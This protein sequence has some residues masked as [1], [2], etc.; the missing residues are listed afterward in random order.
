MGTWKT[1]K[2]RSHVNEIQ[3]E[4]LF[5]EMSRALDSINE[6]MEFC[7]YHYKEIESLIANHMARNAD[8]NY[9]QLRFTEDES[10][11]NNEY[12]FTVACKAHIIALIRTLHSLPDLIA[13]VIYIS[14]GLNLK[15]E[16]KIGRKQNIDFKVIKRI[17]ENKSEYEKLSAKM[18]E[19]V[20]CEEYKYFNRLANN[21]KHKSNIRPNL[22]YNLK[23]KG[24]NIYEFN[25]DAFENY[26]KR[27]ALAFIENEFKREHDLIVC[28][29]NMLN[30][31]I[32]SRHSF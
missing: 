16:T 30:Q 3:K 23:G 9:F 19:L 2:L 27:P 18:D 24:R 11:K 6:N 28:I 29:G 5:L 4:V 8:N 31:F 26:P 20:T 1:V 25:F 17:L 21:I 22:T 13:H 12:Q 14:L 10:V 15:N 32:D 7:F